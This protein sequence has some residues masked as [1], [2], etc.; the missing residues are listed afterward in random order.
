MRKQ[1]MKR[2]LSVYWNLFDAEIMTISPKWIIRQTSIQNRITSSSQL[3]RKR[4]K[5]LNTFVTHTL[6]HA[7]IAYS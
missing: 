1:K 3:I 7:S 2:K 4:G 6:T 5:T